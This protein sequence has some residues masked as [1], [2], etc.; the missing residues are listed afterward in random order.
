[1]SLLMVEKLV[2]GVLVLDLRGRV[3]LGEETEALRERIKRLIAA[4]HLKMVLNLEELAY[5]DSSGLST[6]ISSFVSVRNQGGQLKLL[7][8]TRRVSDVMQITKL[9]TVFEIYD[10]ME[11]VQR[12]FAAPP[13]D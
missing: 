9:S 6:L 12:S 3:T 2:G 11:D 7:R 4:G 1:M 5:I 13:G 8:L 10:S